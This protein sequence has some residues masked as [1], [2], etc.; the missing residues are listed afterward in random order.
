MIID[1]TGFTIDSTEIEQYLVQVDFGY[2]KLW[3]SDTGR[4][5]AGKQTGT[6]IGI[7]PKFTLYFRKL[8]RNELNIVTNLLDK[9]TQTVRYYDDNAGAYKTITTYSGDYTIVNKN[10]DTN[11][12]FNCSL[13]AVEKRS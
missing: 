13:I 7:F 12:P 1:K 5:L 2:H 3:A 6:L 9:A 11:E 10:I 4:N 8:S